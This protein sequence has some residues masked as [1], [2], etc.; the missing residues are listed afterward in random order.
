MP[1]IEEANGHRANGVLPILQPPPLSG[2]RPNADELS[3]DLRAALAAVRPLR[4]AVPRDAHTAYSLGTEREGNA[5]LIDSDGLR[6]APATHF[7][8]RGGDGKSLAT[9]VAELVG[10]LP[11][12]SLGRA[13]DPF[14]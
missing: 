4:S 11:V 13:L 7:E 8:L 5:V 1:G 12:T 10:H 9:P 3:F 14:R 6:L 2:P